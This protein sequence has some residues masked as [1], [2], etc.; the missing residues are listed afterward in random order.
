MAGLNVYSKFS[1]FSI[2]HPNGTETSSKK[3]DTQKN[4]KATKIDER[5]IS[6]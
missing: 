4:K 1:A 3:C 5:L 6:C 2:T